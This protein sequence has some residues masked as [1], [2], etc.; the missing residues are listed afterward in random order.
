MCLRWVCKSGCLWW[1]VAKVSVV[2]V[3]GGKSGCV[4]VGW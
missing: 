3:T 2:A 1:V 4:C